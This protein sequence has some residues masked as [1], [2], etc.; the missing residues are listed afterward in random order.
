MKVRCRIA[1]TTN[2]TEQLISPTAIAFD[3]N[4][5]GLLAGQAYE[6]QYLM[7]D[8]AGNQTLT[9]WAAL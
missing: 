2:W 4:L 9:E 8:N 7:E 5:T 6:Y 3:V 1:G